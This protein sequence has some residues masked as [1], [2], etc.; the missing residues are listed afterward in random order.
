[1]LNILYIGPNQSE[2][3]DAH[4]PGSVAAAKWSRGFLSGLSKVAK[5]TALAHTYYYPWPKGGKLWSLYDKRLYPEDWDCEVVGYPVLRYV[6]EWWWTWSYARKARRIIRDRKIDIVIMYNCYEKWQVSV[7]EVVREA[8]PQVKIVPIIL[9]GADPR[10]DNWGWVK[11]AAK[12]SDAFVVLS[13]WMRRHLPIEVGCPSFHLDGGAEEWRG[14]RVGVDSM[15]SERHYTIVYTGELTRWSGVDFLIEVVK[16]WRREDVEFVICGRVISDHMD[17]LKNDPRVNLKGYLKDA[18]LDSLCQ[19]ADAFLNVR[20]PNHGD[21]VL[22]FPSKLPRYLSYGKPVVSN[23]LVSLS[24]EYDDVLF[25]DKD[26]SVVGFIDQLDR[27]LSL[28]DDERSHLAEKTRQ[29][30][31]AEKLWDAQA[32]KTLD[33]IRAEIMKEV[34]HA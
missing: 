13:Y 6:R 3:A 15:E 7:L 27:A 14:T 1:M 16:S 18:E 12:Y 20:D 22:N 9:D 8:H 21:N 4:C 11:A 32:R 2:W 29:W 33:W 24:P 31:V 30:F 17:E 28:N 19:R 26:N 25:V 34:E 10:K 23:A 5:V